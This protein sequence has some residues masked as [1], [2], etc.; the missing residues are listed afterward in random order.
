M[1]WSRCRDRPQP[2]PPP[3]PP[4]SREDGAQRAAELSQP[5]PLPSRRRA[6][7]GR[8]RFEERTGA[9]GPEGREQARMEDPK[10][11]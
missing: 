10:S 6:P 5:Q 1:K 2:P 7:P 4:A 8:Q 9:A 11:R 3:P